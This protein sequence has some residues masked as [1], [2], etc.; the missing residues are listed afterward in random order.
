MKKFA[1]TNGKPAL[2]RAG[3]PYLMPDGTK[4]HQAP[5]VEKT[6][7]GK[8][9]IPLPV[10]KEGTAAAFR[11][12]KKRT[13]KNLPTGIPIMK[14]I[15]CVILFTV[16]GVGDREIADALDISPNDLKSVRAHPA[17]AE[18]FDAMIDEFINAN[19]DNIQA[20]LAAHS[21]LALDQVQTLMVGAKKEETRLKASSDW[22]DRAG[23]H[24][25]G[26]NDRVGSGLSDLRITIVEGEQ[27]AIGIEINSSA[28]HGGLNGKESHEE[29]E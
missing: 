9:V 21:G 15:A 17:Y 22:L 26:P 28:I 12:T 29:V 8:M 13:L 6:E 23:V 4:I 11:S 18:C 5:L 24:R 3:D 20:R 27:K 14:G 10:E 7:T 2:A 25:K 1:K 16:M 19:N